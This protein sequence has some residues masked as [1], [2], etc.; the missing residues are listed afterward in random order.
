MLYRKG[1]ELH[2]PVYT[3]KQL[4]NV[5]F[6]VK[7]YSKRLDE[8]DQKELEKPVDE[9]KLYFISPDDPNKTKLL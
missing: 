2:V 5:R 7:E 4:S 6:A 1:K 8:A 3:C 9:S